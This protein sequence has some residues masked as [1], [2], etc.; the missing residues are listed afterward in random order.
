MPSPRWLLPCKKVIRT[1]SLFFFGQL[2]PGPPS[3]SS[4]GEGFVAGLLKTIFS[5]F[6]LKSGLSSH[7]RNCSLLGNFPGRIAPFAFKLKPHF[8]GRDAVFPPPDKLHQNFIS[9][10]FP[11]FSP[12][13][14]EKGPGS[15]FSSWLKE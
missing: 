5:F 10:G 13:S 3:L 9:F 14:L 2:V 15:S 1:F 11:P 8:S 4:L 7:L 12:F 6:I